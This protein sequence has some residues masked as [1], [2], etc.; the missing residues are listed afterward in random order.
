MARSFLFDFDD[1]GLLLKFVGRIKGFCDKSESHDKQQGPEYRSGDFVQLEGFHRRARSSEAV[2]VTI[3]NIGMKNSERM[4]ITSDSIPT[5][6]ENTG[7]S[8]QSA[9][10]DTEAS[11]D[12]DGR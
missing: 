8:R 9:T 4:P 5:G 12:N 1:I 7:N 2:I 10:T 6:A 3:A 11:G